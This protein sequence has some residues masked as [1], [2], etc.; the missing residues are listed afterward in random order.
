[1]SDATGY[2]TGEIR[3]GLFRSGFSLAEQDAQKHQFYQ[4]LSCASD[5]GAQGQIGQCGDSHHGLLRH[6]IDFWML[7][8]NSC[9]PRAF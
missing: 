9:M 2:P 1:M 6:V 7:L 3:A 5:P 4:G 8:S